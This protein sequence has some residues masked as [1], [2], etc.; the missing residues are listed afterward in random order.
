[1]LFPSYFYH[2]T[3]PFHTDEARISIAFDLIPE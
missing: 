3:I 1:V 2:Q